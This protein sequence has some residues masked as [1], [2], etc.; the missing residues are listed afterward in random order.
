[1][2]EFVSLSTLSFSGNNRYHEKA[3]RSFNYHQR[4]PL[5]ASAADDGVIHV[6]HSMVY[7]DL[8]RNPLLV[9]VKILRGHAI[10]NKLGVLTCAFHPTQPWLFTGGA[11]FK[12]YLV[13]LIVDLFH[14]SR[15][16]LTK[17]S[18]FAPK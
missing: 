12:T 3:L 13:V 10:E 15:L 7:S 14:S 16:R 9:P 1:M 6:F 2:Y 8:M 5:M 4:Y 17:L 18:H 11:V